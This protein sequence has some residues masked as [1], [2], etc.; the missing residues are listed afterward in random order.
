[1]NREFHPVT[2][3][4][5][6][7]QAPTD[8]AGQAV[9]WESLMQLPIAHIPNS[10]HLSESERGELLVKFLHARGMFEA[11]PDAEQQAYEAMTPEE[12][13][14]YVE[15]SR[16]YLIHAKAETAYEPDVW[17]KLLI[18]MYT[19]PQTVAEEFTELRAGMSPYEEVVMIRWIETTHKQW[20]EKCKE[21]FGRWSLPWQNP[22]GQGLGVAH[23][24]HWDDVEQL[25]E[26]LR[27][28]YKLYMADEIYKKIDADLDGV[29]PMDYLYDLWAHTGG[30]ESFGWDRFCDLMTGF[31]GIPDEPLQIL[32]NNLQERRRADYMLQMV[33]DSDAI[34]SSLKDPEATF[35]PFD[36][37][38][39]F[40]LRGDM[41]AYVA[42][43]R[44][45]SEDQ[46]E[47]YTEW[48]RPFRFTARI[49]KPP[50]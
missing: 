5:P 33:N 3:E 48:E 19:H 14:S 12:Q 37:Y 49:I 29:V 39:I 34:M 31:Y 41:S 1:M 36:P 9:W 20:L 38:P 10:E 23:R 8:Q 42:A 47:V 30:E 16:L 25:D 15:W 21:V 32:K 46:Q 7:Q 22:D 35:E 44:E 24:Q 28:F 27:D 18:D 2:T 4:G 11:D 43:F 26:D 17:G 45:L 13:T 40:A 50:K 6:G